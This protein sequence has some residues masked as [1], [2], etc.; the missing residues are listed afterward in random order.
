MQKVLKFILISLM[1]LTLLAGCVEK[2]VLEQLGIVTAYGF[3]KA[4][5][6][7]MLQSTT[8]LFQFNPDITDASQII[9]SE[10]HTFRELKKNANKKSGYKIVSGQLR[11]ILYG[12]ELAREGIFPYIDTL[13][14]DAAISDMVYIAV[15]NQPTQHV[16][17]AT[18]YEQSPNIGTYI[19][20]LIETA[21]EDERLNS[22]T[23]HEFTRAFFTIGQDPLVPIIKNHNDK[24]QLTGLAIFQDDRY[25]DELPLDDIFY[26]LLMTKQLKAGKVELNFPI[27]SFLNYMEDYEKPDSDQVFVVLEKISNKTDVKITDIENLKYRVDINL[28]GRLVELTERIDLSNREALD[29][30]EK[31]I[32]KQIETK[33]EELIEK[34][35]EANADFYGFGKKYISKKEGKNITKEQWRDMFQDIDVQVNVS[36]TIRSYGIIE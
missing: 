22:N 7:D 4:N 32:N 29:L 2:N 21:I 33:I 11:T 13:E 17:S 10:G 12:P 23:L 15:S 26:V 24:A 19:Q 1:S 27:E 30:L 9:Y 3:D 14:R 35:K 18:N 31:T 36:T 5:G 6:N 25:V 20:R 16:L 8:V 34:S 28:E